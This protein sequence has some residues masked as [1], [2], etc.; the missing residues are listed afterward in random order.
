[1]LDIKQLNTFYGSSHIL[2]DIQLSVPARGRTAIVGRNGAGKTTLLKSIMNA[3]PTVQGTIE[4]RGRELGD[5]PAH[6][7]ARLGI[8]LI[9]EDRRIFGH[10]TV[11]ENLRLAEE[12]TAPHKQPTPVADLLRMFPMLEPLTERH[13]SQL[14]GGQQ[15]MLA[16]ARGLIPSPD[17]LLLDEPTEG[18]APVIVQQMARTVNAICQNS[19]VALLLSEQNLWFARQ[20]ST[21]LYVIDSGKIVFEGPWTEFDADPG[22]KARYL[23][24]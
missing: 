11:E 12:G 15:Q 8:S 10:L 5:L 9:P 1:M 19:G 17:L 4:W 3:G 20:C 2:H 23:A 6:K 21:Y 24:I 22:I 7:R 14:S 16:V 18:L 13:G